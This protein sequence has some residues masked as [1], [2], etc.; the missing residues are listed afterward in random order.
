MKCRSIKISDLKKGETKGERFFKQL[1]LEFPDFIEFDDLNGKI[2]TRHSKEN[3][4][5]VWELKDFSLCYV[6]NHDNLEDFK[7]W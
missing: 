4:Y 5:R 2:V 7:I 3:L 1:I 6:L